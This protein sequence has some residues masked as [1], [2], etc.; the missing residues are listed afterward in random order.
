MKDKKIL[1]NPNCYQQFGLSRI[2]FWVVCQKH[3]DGGRFSEFYT[4]RSVWA[5]YTPLRCS[6]VERTIHSAGAGTAFGVCSR[7]NS[8]RRTAWTTQRV[9]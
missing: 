7:G 6:G 2:V 1:L 8:S 3:F 4:I 9:E 5:R